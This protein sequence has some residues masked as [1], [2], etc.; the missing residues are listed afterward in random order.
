MSK[1][2]KH[3]RM[4]DERHGIEEN[5]GFDSRRYG[6]RRKELAKLKVKERRRDRKKHNSMLE[7]PDALH[8]ARPV[9]ATRSA[10]S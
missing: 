1:S 8:P 4:Y 2:Y 10:W 9:E 5:D 3:Q 7:N 6:N